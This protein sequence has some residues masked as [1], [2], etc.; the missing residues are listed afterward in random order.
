[1]TMEWILLP[2]N[3]EV[4]IAALLLEH[5]MVTSVHL[6]KTRAIES[7]LQRQVCSR[8][9]GISFAPNKYIV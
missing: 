6:Q 2:D 8:I 3:L 5:Y 9:Y 1:M 7:L 4:L